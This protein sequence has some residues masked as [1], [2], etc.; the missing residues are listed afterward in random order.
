MARRKKLPVGKAAQTA[1]EKLGRQE[2]NRKAQDLVRLAL[3]SEHRRG[4][5]RRD[6]ITEKGAP[7]PGLGLLPR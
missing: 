7:G 5:L 3:F 2:L 6:E 1:G 4:A